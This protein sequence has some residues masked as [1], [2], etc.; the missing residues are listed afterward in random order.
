MTRAETAAAKP[1]KSERD[2]LKD[3]TR[4][5]N[6]RGKALLK[7]AREHAGEYVARSLDA[8]KELA[9]GK[10]LADLEERLV[11]KG[12]DPSKVVIAR[13]QSPDDAEML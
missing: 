5:L 8:T 4:N 7:E 12:V 13:V 1:A 3:F 10:T 11:Q 6:R 9:Y 2:Q